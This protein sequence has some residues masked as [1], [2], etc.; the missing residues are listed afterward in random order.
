MGEE[1]AYLLQGGKE[2]RRKVKKKK[3]KQELYSETKKLKWTQRS[4]E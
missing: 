2:W 3:N 1:Q 4:Q